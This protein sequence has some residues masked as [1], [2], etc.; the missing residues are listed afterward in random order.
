M[1]PFSEPFDR[2]DTL[3]PEEL[4]TWWTRRL[5]SVL[6]TAGAELPFYRRRFEE[7]RFDPA[8]FR[9]LDDLVR[10]PVFGKADVLA[11][12]GERGGAAVGLER[13][14][15]S[16]RGNTMSMSSGTEGTT[17]ILH[18]AAWRKLQGYSA[19]RCHWWAGLR[20]GSPFV[21]SAPAWHSYAA[22]QPYIAERFGMPCIV[23][24]GTYLPH[25]ADRIVDAFLRFR[26]RFV[27]MFL[28]MVFSIVAASRR[29]GERPE[30]IFGS[31]ETLV[32]TGAPI[33]P[34]MRAHLERMTG[35]ARVAEI[36]GTSENV[37]A[38]DCVHANGLHV[39]PDTCV[40]EVLDPKTRRPVAG[41]ERGSLVHCVLIAEG[42]VYLR[43]DS[44]D[45]AVI[46][47]DP[48]PCGLPS[49]RI[50]VLG[51]WE[52][53]FSLFGRRLLPY[54]VQLALEEDVPE[55]AGV[56][57]V[58]VR[59]PIAEGRLRLL[60]PEPEAR[61][62]ALAGEILAA[63]GRRFSV[64]VEVNWV[65]DLPLRFKG[66]APVLSESAAVASLVEAG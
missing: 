1:S 42:S 63:L 13:R 23:V 29:R 3:T 64:P 33:T 6:R 43:Y 45:V 36:A 8:T 7:A 40:V 21:L 51:R 22:V 47:S 35:V 37:L 19:A 10:V 56:P 17:F 59:E 52:N 26:P 41:G 53:S 61:A 32:V 66:V 65:R 62:A 39:V 2:L 24:A 60:L 18:T 9:T 12:Q 50:K 5:A 28:P 20:G 15:K 4:R 58:I 14:R 57:C 27:T 16:R 31:V 54:D 48:C 25:F 30:T 49:P 55:L 44:G 38:V 46:H 11:A 34:G